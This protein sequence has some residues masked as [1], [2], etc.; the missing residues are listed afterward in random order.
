MNLITK[1]GLLIL[2]VTSAMAATFSSTVVAEPEVNQQYYCKG[3]YGNKNDKG[4]WDW[5]FTASSEQEA[6]KQTQEQY[7]VDGPNPFVNIRECT[8]QK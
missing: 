4:K 3:N 6:R 1:R 7:K 2:S 8:L 5:I